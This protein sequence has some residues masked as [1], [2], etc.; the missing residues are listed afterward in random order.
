MAIILDGHLEEEQAILIDHQIYLPYKFLNNSLDSR[1]YWD[2][3]TDYLLFTDAIKI[4]EIAI[5]NG[6]NVYREDSTLYVS[7]DLVKTYIEVQTE[8]F[9]DPN[10]ICLKKMGKVR[11]YK[12]VR[13]QTN[14]RTFSGLNSPII[15]KIDAEEEVEII[16]EINRW[17]FV[18]TSDGQIGYVL[19]YM[20]SGDYSRLETLEPKKEE[21]EYTSLSLEQPVCLVWHQ[22]FQKSANDKLESLLKQTKGV[23]VVSPTWFSITKNDGSYTSF[24]DASYVEKAHQLGLQVWALVDD[25]NQDMS[26]YQ[27]LS[28]TT[29]RLKLVDNLIEDVRKVGADG[30]NIDFEYVGEDSG[31]HFLQFLR[32]LSVKCRKEKLFLSVDNMNPTYIRKQYHLSSQA[33]LVDYVMIMAYDEYWKNSQAGPNA[34]ISYVEKGMDV[35][36]ESVPKEKLV[37]GIPFYARVWKEVPEEY[38]T[39]TKNI[40]EDGNSEYSRYELTSSAYSMDAVSELIEKY[41]ANDRIAWDEN[42]GL[43]YVEIPLEHGKYRI[44]IEDARSLEE[45]LK[46]VQQKKTAGIA[47]WKLGLE[48]KDV[49]PMINSYYK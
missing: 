15:R 5:K 32:E 23:N 7:L 13:H 10:R 37:T 42:L 21:A 29:T 41:K 47:G 6:Q 25:F 49:W 8:V 4:Q 14:I 28:N 40:R 44:W 3:H 39:D 20:L 48:S 11:Q 26:I 35:A 30:I 12:E 33:T 2:E 43:N 31:T 16:N 36:L 9:K 19:N 18:Q 38:A 17:T 27:V 34:S 46:L 22:V 45:K 1:F 24:A